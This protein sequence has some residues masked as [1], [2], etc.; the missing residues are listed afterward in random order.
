MDWFKLF[1]V[2][3]GL[4]ILRNSGPAWSEQRRFSLQTMKDLSLKN[5]ALETIITEEALALCDHLKSLNGDIVHNVRSVVANV[6]TYTVH[7]TLCSTTLLFTLVSY[8]YF[9]EVFYPSSLNTIWR[10]IASERFDTDD[11]KLK[12]LMAVLDNLGQRVSHIVESCLTTWR[13]CKVYIA[14]TY[15]FCY[16]RHFFPIL[17]VLINCHTLNKCHI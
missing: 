15:C 3:T 12:N 14:E 2:G 10:L 13:L 7:R 16:P 8:V 9:R 6:T 17:L 4:G 5:G 11:Y 1:V